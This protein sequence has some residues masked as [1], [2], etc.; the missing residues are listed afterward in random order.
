MDIYIAFLIAC[1]HL[2][3]KIFLFSKLSEKNFF[4][5]QWLKVGMS[6][7]QYKKNTIKKYSYLS[8]H[9]SSSN[10][11]SYNNPNELLN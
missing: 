5:P 6:W 10:I 7:E 8:Y 2:F 1:Q 3:K 9:F 11:A 4:F